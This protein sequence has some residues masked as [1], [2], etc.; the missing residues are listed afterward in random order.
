MLTTEAQRTQRTLL[1]KPPAAG[2]SLLTT[3]AQRTQRTLLYKPPAARRLIANHRGTEN[4][5]NVTV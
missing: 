1:Y 4:T 2:D 5:E 3:E